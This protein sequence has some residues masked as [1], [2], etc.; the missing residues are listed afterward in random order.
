[1][2]NQNPNKIAMTNSS[3]AG[4]AE[5]SYK[6]GHSKIYTKLA[7]SAMSRFY[8]KVTIARYT[9]GGCPTCLLMAI[10]KTLAISRQTNKAALAITLKHRPCCA[11]PFKLKP[12]NT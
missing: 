5:E 9:R 12:N 4:S 8:C 3:L 1:M 6:I 11:S 7:Y 10:S 2:K